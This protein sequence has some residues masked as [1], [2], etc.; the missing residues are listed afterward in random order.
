MNWLNSENLNAGKGLKSDIAAA[1]GKVLK[2]SRIHQRHGRLQRL[3]I[4][5]KTVLEKSKLVE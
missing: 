3:E 4:K 5:M 2:T 1:V